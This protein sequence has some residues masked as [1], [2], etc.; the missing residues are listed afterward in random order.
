MVT[1]S[2]S[3]RALERA[4]DVRVARAQL[5]RKLCGGEVRTADVVLHPPREAETMSV[6]DL[7][8]CQRQWGRSRTHR[9]LGPFQISEIKTV[10]SLTDR[11]RIAVAA[12]LSMQKAGAGGEP[13]A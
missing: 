9:F 12:S 5:K 2:Q 7:L 8:R 1:V 3:M 6:F 10:G 4:N 11:Q 13:A